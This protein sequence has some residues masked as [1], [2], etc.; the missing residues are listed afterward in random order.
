[1]IGKPQ[2]F[3]FWLATEHLEAPVSP[4]VADVPPSADLDDPEAHHKINLDVTNDRDADARKVTM[5][6]MLCPLIS[7]VN[8][9]AETLLMVMTSSTTQ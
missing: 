8:S 6:Q 9:A 2:P 4:D 3:T 7:A 5:D 1:M